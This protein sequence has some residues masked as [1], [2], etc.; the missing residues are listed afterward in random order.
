MKFIHV[1]GS[2]DLSAFDFHQMGRCLNQSSIPVQ[3]QLTVEIANDRS[4]SLKPNQSS[5]SRL[6]LQ[7]KAD[8]VF[9][10]TTIR[11][12]D[13]MQRIYLQQCRLIYKHA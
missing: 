12:Y 8:E 2:A 13:N 7:K 5:V 9:I 6:G 11:K 3:F 4:V 1:I 10:K